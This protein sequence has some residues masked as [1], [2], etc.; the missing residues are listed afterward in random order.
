MFDSEEVEDSHG[1]GHLSRRVPL[2]AVQAALHDNNKCI[3]LAF[4]RPHDQP[5]LVADDPTVFPV[6]YFLIGDR[7]W[8]L[9]TVGKAA[10]AGAQDHGALALLN[11]RALL[12]EV[13]TGLLDL[14][15]GVHLP[16]L[17][18]ILTTLHVASAL[19]NT[20]TAVLCLNRLIC[21]LFRFHVLCAGFL[22]ANK[23]V[24]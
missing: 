15:V 3:W 16:F 8:I 23:L 2:V 18:P 10:E 11:L 17:L 21:G 14:F 22:V 4:K 13:R 6:G 19:R 5:G 24:F 12:N 9:D 20:L 1:K 7:C